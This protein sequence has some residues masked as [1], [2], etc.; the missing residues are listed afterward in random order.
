MPRVAI[1]GASFT[2]GTGPGRAGE[3]WAVLLA[4]LLRWDAVV[5]GV[6]GAGY[7]HPGAGHRGPM[8]AMLSRI[9]LR[10]LA[11]ALVIVQAGHDDIGVPA[12]LER[13]RVTQ[14]IALIRAEAPEARIALVT[15]FPGRRRTAADYQTDQVIVAAARAA[16]P[17]VIIMDPLAQGWTFPRTR[18]GLHPT[19]AGDAWIARKVAGLLGQHGIRPA[20]PR[21]PGGPV[22]CDSGIPVGPPVPARPQPRS[23]GW[24]AADGW[25][26]HQGAAAGCGLGADRAAVA[27][28]HLAGDGQPEPGAGHRAGRGGP[29][30]AVEDERP[31]LRCD[32]GPVVAHGELAA[33][34]DHLDRA[35]RRAEL[36]RVVQQ[37]T[38]RDLQPLGAAEHQAR[39][40][41]GG[42]DGPRP[43]PAGALQ[44]GRHHLVQAHVAWPAA[45][46]LSGSGSAQAAAR[47]GPVR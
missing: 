23:D 14:V 4:R 6:P 34:Q 2:A 10:A 5:Y 37:V 35:A 47:P 31:V 12:R 21:G 13:E 7:V 15:V 9:G 42:E 36:S 33:Q 45:R 28:G 26:T 24:F 30:E 38:H 1:V 41:I 20:P 46:Q 29:V 44:R 3:S 27:F 25:R 8:A 22:I 16:D 39:R 19:A 17:G 43:V 32:T 40:E 11:P 18:D